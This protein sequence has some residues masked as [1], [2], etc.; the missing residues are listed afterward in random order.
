VEFRETTVG[1]SPGGSMTNCRPTLEMGV[2]ET[3]SMSTQSGV[4]RAEKAEILRF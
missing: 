1:G 4:E 3:F 2:L